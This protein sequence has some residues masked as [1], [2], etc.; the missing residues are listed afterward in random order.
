MLIHILNPGMRDR[1]FEILEAGIRHYIKTGE[2]ITSERVYK[3]RDF[4]IKPAMIRCELSELDDAGYLEQNRPSGGREPTP[5]AYRLFVKH[6]LERDEKKEK[7]AS[8]KSSVKSLVRDLEGGDHEAIVD[9]LSEALEMLGVGYSPKYQELYQRGLSDL[10]S[11]LDMQMK[12]DII[13]VIED[14]ESFPERLEEV[15]SL[16]EEESF[17]PKVFIGPSPITKSK[18]LS[19]IAGK[20]SSKDGPLFL[21]AVGPTRMDY[22]KPINIFKSLREFSE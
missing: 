10:L 11:Q 8:V 20:F 7:S 19:V 4:G 3:M 15:Y 14:F 5:K 9:E 21:F 12:E 6:L 16:W 17:W 2:P 22:T 18:H 13:R 1:A